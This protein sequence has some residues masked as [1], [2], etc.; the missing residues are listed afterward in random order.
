MRDGTRSLEGSFAPPG[1]NRMA[2]WTDNHG[3]RFA[4]PVATVPGPVGAD[5]G[6]RPTHGDDLPPLG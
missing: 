4:P 2:G 5:R 6:D 1:L 3:F